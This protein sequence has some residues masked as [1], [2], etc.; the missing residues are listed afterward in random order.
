MQ[1]GVTVTRAANRAY[2]QLRPLKVTYGV[3]PYAAGSTLFEMGNTKVL[4]AVTLQNGV[5]HFLRG[6]KTGWMTAEYSLLPSATPVR[7]V[8][9][10]TANRRSGR[11]IEISRLIGRALRSVC[12]LSVLGEQTIFIDCDVLQADGGTRTASI[13]GAFL[14]LRAAQERWKLQGMITGQ[15]SVIRDE[16]AAV[17]VGL[18]DSGP[19]LDMDFAEDS[20]ID[21]DYNFVLTRSGKVVE[22]QGAAEQAPIGWDNYEHMRILAVQGAQELF[23]FYDNHKPPKENPEQSSYLLSSIAAQMAF[24]DRS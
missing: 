13:T 23:S 22:I 1:K 20:V 2:D 3:Y 12:D 4:C 18:G 15:S 5:P 7:T 11:V 16:L 10:I 21:A 19:L 8:R 24:D 6:K 9:E 17:S 14:A